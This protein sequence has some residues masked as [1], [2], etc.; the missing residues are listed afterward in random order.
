[1]KT[2][3]ALLALRIYG[4]LYMMLGHGWPKMLKL[5]GNEP[6]QFA[7][8]FG[9]GMTVSLALAVFTEVLCAFFV[10]I[11]VA[12]R[13]AAIPLAAT[14]AVAAFYVHASDPWDRKELAI[15]YLCVYIALFCLGGGRIG[16]DRFIKRASN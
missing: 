16:F 3:I 7:D 2:D 10:T 13:W 11:G 6:I 5:F 4:G 15:G 14:M 12:T 8:L 9:M 1:M